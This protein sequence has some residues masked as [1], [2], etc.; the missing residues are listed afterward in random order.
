M[1]AVSLVC[2]SHKPVTALPYV[3]YTIDAFLWPDTRLRTLEIASKHG[4]VCLLD[5]LLKNEWSGFSRKARE[6]RLRNAIMDA[7]CYRYDVQ[8]VKWWI[9]RYMPDQDVF[10]MVK[11]YCLA[12]NY[13][14]VPVLEWIDQATNGSLPCLERPTSCSTPDTVTWL[15]DH[16]VHHASNF[17]SLYIGSSPASFQSFK[18]CLMHQDEDPTF[19]IMYT[20]KILHAALESGTLEDLLWLYDHRP[21]FFG[22]SIL[23]NAIRYGNLD[24]V[25]W[26]VNVNPAHYFN[27]PERTF[28]E[29]SD[30]SGPYRYNLAMIKWILCE[31]DWRRGSN[32]TQWMREARDYA[33]RS[34]NVVMLEFVYTVYIE[35]SASPQ[36]AAVALRKWVADGPSIMDKAAAKGHLDM[37]K[38][39]HSHPGERC[40]TNAMDL[41][42]T[43]G[44]LA[45]VQWL[46]ENRSEGCTTE[47]MNGAAA[48]GHLAVVQW[49]H[50]NR[51]EGCTFKAIDCAAE[52]GHLDIARYLHANRWEGCTPNALNQAAINAHYDV[53]KWLYENRSEQDFTTCHSQVIKCQALYTKHGEHFAE[54]FVQYS[55]VQTIEMLLSSV[56]VWRVT[57]S[58]S[59]DRA[60]VV[61]SIERRIATKYSN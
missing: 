24:A 26:L 22:P 41:A 40:T 29:E 11:V 50:E 47:A 44:H 4:F 2:D 59:A 33:A 57:Q 17:P 19:N 43:N 5:R 7:V 55:D 32:R 37:M 9:R 3:V 15:L 35:R 58:S 12:I 36:A 53:F 49:L 45:V 46:H 30:D 56:Y 8:V 6:Q 10:P 21:R 18:R 52:N 16:G 38:V 14:C 60:K 13:D 39:L 23:K 20:K 42:A 1:V 31:F 34:G 51:F 61:G 27:N 25:K 28:D 54:R 48:E